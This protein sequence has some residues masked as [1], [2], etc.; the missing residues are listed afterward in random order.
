M[1]LCPRTGRMS[2]SSR[3]SAFRPFAPRIPETSPL[4]ANAPGREQDYIC[5]ENV[6]CPCFL[7]DVG[8]GGEA[9][10]FR[11]TRVAAGLEQPRLFVELRGGNKALGPVGRH[12]DGVAA[13][14]QLVDRLGAEAG[15]DAHVFRRVVVRSEEARKVVRGQLRRLDRL[16]DRHAERLPVQDELQRP[17][18]LLVAAHR[19]EGHPRLAAPERE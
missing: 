11:A 10:G 13:P 2:G 15:L 5:A 9:L 3:S 17:L 8:E 14:T 4:A 16:L 19:A 6:V 1:T 12:L 18:L 7:P